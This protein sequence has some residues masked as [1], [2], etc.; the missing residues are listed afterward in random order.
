MEGEP[1]RARGTVIETPDWTWVGLDGEEGQ[2]RS[3][4]LRSVAK[5][6]VALDAE[7]RA[8][9]MD[10]IRQWHEDL[11]A[12]RVEHP[13]DNE[14]ILGETCLLTRIAGQ[15]LC[16]WEQAGLPLRHEASAFNVRVTSIV[17]GKK[18]ADEVFVPPGGPPSAPTIDSSS[19]DAEALL[20]ALAA[21]NYAPI[22]K[23]TA[24]RLSPPA[25]P[26]G[27]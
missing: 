19:P 5:A 20:E 10:T 26:G 8:R 24:V 23:L 2:A 11:E 21:G 18:I 14:E 16:M 25:A 22:A 6:Y 3:R 13:G 17:R 27:E 1:A 12:A 4:P 9:V 15:T 7:Q